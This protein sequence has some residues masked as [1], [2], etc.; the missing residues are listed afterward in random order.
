MTGTLTRANRTNLVDV[1][2]SMWDAAVRSCG[3]HLLQS[4]RWG[5]FK[6]HFGWDV[7][8]I[9][10]QRE[11][12]AAIAQVLFRSKA[13]VSIGYIPRGPAWPHGDPDA[14]G[15][16]WARVDIHTADA[17]ALA[18]LALE[19]SEQALHPTRRS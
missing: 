8:R 4:W 2:P 13:G 7:E 15:E 16:L 14:V 17:K 6:N 18:F 11:E 1:D 5:E 3:G 19:M 12:R 9:A 10:V